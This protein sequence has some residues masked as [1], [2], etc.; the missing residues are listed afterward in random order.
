MTALTK[1]A[2]SKDTPLMVH[3]PPLTPPPPTSLIKGSRNDL[4]NWVTSPVNAAP[5]TMPTAR[6]TTL[7]RMMK[8]LKPLSICTPARV[9]GPGAR[10]P[11]CPQPV[12]DKLRRTGL[13]GE[14]A[15]SVERRL[16]GGDRLVDRRVGPQD[17]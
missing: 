4:G 9:V 10:A 11:S 3:V 7:P 6:S 16:L 12:D 14:A 17:L 13:A 5:M 2:Q 1:A 8:S 15:R